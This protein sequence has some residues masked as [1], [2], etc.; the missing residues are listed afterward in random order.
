ME[1]QEL[2]EKFKALHAEFMEFSESDRNSEDG[3]K[4]MEMLQSY[5]NQLKQIEKS[6]DIMHRP[7]GNY[8]A[9]FIP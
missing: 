9:A 1:Y 2:R 7:I 4:C 5:E 6:I 8:K 3:K